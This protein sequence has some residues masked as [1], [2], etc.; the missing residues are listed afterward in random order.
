[1][2][3]SQFV[4]PRGPATW[5]QLLPVM[6]CKLVKSMNRLLDWYEGF[7]LNDLYTKQQ[8][9]KEKKTYEYAIC[10]FCV[11]LFSLHHFVYKN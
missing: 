8:R 1:M 9:E 4:G 11:F 6:L 10:F 5:N 3:L 7:M 2:K